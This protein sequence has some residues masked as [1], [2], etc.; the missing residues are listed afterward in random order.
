MLEGI[1]AGEVM[2]PGNASLRETD[3]PIVAA[4]TLVQTRHQGLPVLNAADGLV[5]DIT[6]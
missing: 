3:T 5:G 4:D 1:T 2:E 6:L